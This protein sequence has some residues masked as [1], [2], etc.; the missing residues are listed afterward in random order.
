MCY[1][2]GQLVTRLEFIRLKNLEK[3]IMELHDKPVQ[4]G[5]DYDDWPV[6]VP[7]NGGKDID[8]VE[9]EWGFIPSYLP[10]R[11][12]VEKFRR[13]YKKENGEF[14]PPKT[15]LNAVSEELLKPGKM[16]R[17]AALKRRCL[18]I[19]FGFYEWRHVAKTGKKGQVLKA[20][21]KFPYHVK[22]KEREYFFIAGIWQPWT[23]RE[24][25]E[26]IN[27]CALLTTNA[28]SLMQQVHNS[29]LRMPTIL[30]EDLAYEW[31]QDGL[32]EERISEIA[33]FQFPGSQ[34]EA[35]TINKDFL[36]REVP[37]EECVY[38][39]LPA[40]VI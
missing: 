37:T 26:M 17:D 15:T 14:V 32:S 12:E 40:L 31:I 33:S 11:E 16:F 24:T 9:M 6:V 13:G 2:N 34:M 28:N 39:E 8:V 25:G 5:F 30:N 23:D 27:S 21:E 20:T 18:F 1:Y 7:V 10:T 4:S 3:K 22:V 35:R 36:N 38:S 19:S 29:K